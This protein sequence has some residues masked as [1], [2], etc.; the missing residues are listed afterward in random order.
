MSGKVKF[1]VH[2]FK[3]KSIYIFKLAAYIVPKSYSVLHTKVVIAISYG[4]GDE[5]NLPNEFY[6]EMVGCV[7]FIDP[8]ET[9]HYLQN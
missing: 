9:I 5:H 4:K 8:V 7:I 6:F 2:I 3:W 1:G